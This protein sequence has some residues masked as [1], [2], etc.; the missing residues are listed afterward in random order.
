M[1]GGDSCRLVTRTDPSGSL[2]R[3]FGNE[4]PVSDFPAFV[5]HVAEANRERDGSPVD[6]VARHV[7][8]GATVVGGTE[9]RLWDGTPYVRERV[10]PRA[11]LSATDTAATDADTGAADADTS[12]VDTLADALRDYYDA[13]GWDGVET[14]P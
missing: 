8:V 7:V 11:V 3:P 13:H 6:Y 9:T 10:R 5:A 12:A 2:P 4:P 14:G 1:T